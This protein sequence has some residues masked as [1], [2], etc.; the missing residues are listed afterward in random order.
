MIKL[1]EHLT[2]KTIYVNLDLIVFMMAFPEYVRLV[3]S[4]DGNSFFDVCESP[5]Y[6]L[7]LHNN[8]PV[9]E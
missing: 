1:T 5:E 8:K 4:G 3:Y 6:I 7:H 9:E 2:Q